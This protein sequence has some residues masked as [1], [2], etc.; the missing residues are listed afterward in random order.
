MP[1]ALGAFHDSRVNSTLWLYEHRLCNTGCLT[2]NY[3]IDTAGT[4]CRGSGSARNPAADILYLVFP[5]EGMKLRNSATCLDVERRAH[6]FACCN[7]LGH[8]FPHSVYSGCKAHPCAA[9]KP[10]SGPR[11]NMA[12]HS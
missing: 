7:Q 4:A 11:L 6:N 2:R 5:P 9:D 10:F 3:I 1:D 8:N 12:F